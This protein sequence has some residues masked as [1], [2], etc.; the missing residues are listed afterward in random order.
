MKPIK[1]LM[2]VIEE[3]LDPL[4]FTISEALGFLK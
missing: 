2:E 4:N 1:K 3:K